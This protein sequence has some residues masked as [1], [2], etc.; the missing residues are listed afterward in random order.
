MRLL[1]I[2]IICS[3]FFVCFSAINKYRKQQEKYEIEKEIKLLSSGVEFRRNTL[4]E[5]PKRKKKTTKPTKKR[6][7]KDK[8]IDET[9]GE[10]TLDAKSL[11]DSAIGKLMIE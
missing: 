10:V 5:E 2:L 6:I 7:K 9:L 8:N 4:G 3:I 11:D 1:E